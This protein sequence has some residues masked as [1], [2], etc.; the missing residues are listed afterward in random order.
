MLTAA[1]TLEAPV[2]HALSRSR[3]LALLLVTLAAGAGCGSADDPAGGA[4]QTGDE[5]DLTSVT[6]RERSLAFDGYVYVAANASDATI[7]SAV[8]RQNKSA[9]GALRNAEISANNRELAEIDAKG[10]VKEKVTVVDPASPGA[11]QKPM[12]RVRYRYTDRAVVPV[13]MAKRGAVG[14]AVLHGD[15][16]AQSKRILRECTENTS[17]DQEFESDIWYVFNPTLSE[18][19]DAI[20]AEQQKIDQARAKLAHPDTEVV[21]AETT[22]LYMPVTA[23]LESTKTSTAKT[24]PEYDRLWSGGVQPGKLVV[25]IVSGVMADWAA[26]EK[27]ELAN[28]VGY[29]MFYQMIDEIGRQVPGLALAGTGGADLGTF[30]VGGKTAKGVTWKD[31]SN[32]ELLGSGWPAAFTTAGDRAALKKVVADTLAHHWLSFERK[33]SVKLGSAAA[34]PVTLVVN[35]YYGAETDDAPHRQ[36]LGTSDVVV[37]NGH[38]YIGWGPLDP[39]RYSAASF[40]KSYQLFFFNSCVSFNYYEKDFFKM[41]EGGTKNLDMITNGLESPVYGSGPAVGRLVGALVSGKAVAYKDLL[42][43]G[44]QP[45]EVGIDALRVVDGEVDNA[46]KPSKV[47]LRVT[48]E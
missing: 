44:A 42:V 2:T 43:K 19:R 17:H 16:Q 37:Y 12:L 5:D 22:R 10:F 46:F 25:S 31:L 36:A 28:D 33:A 1:R 14:I 8:K 13:S 23:K 20:D 30:T 48:F 38:S 41:K 40:P 27:P 39:S 7:L 21:P 3:T 29:H 47:P 26:G 35:A 15:Y 9:F 45:T 11:P 24:Y 32:W 34:K 18:C 6:A 4:P